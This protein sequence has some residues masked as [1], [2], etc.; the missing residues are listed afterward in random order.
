MVPF[1]IF[2]NY[3]DAFCYETHLGLRYR[4]IVGVAYIEDELRE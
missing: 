4:D 3:G 2:A 1:D